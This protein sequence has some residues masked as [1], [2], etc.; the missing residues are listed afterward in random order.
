MPSSHPSPRDRRPLAALLLLALAVLAVPAIAANPPD[1]IDLTVARG[2]G[3]ADVTLTWSGGALPYRVYRSATAGV[4]TDLPSYLGEAAFSNVWV[5]TPPAGKVFFYRVVMCT[6]GG[7]CGSGLCA[8]GWCCD[9]A[10]DATCEA[11]NVAGSEGACTF[12]PVGEDPAN[13]CAGAEVCN[14]VG[15]CGSDPNGAPCTTD[16]EC[17]SGHCAD[18]VCCDS[19]CIGVCEA[20]GLAGSE[21]TCSLVP[22]GA[23]PDNECSAEPVTT[24]GRTGQCSGSGSCALHAGGTVCGAASCADGDTANPTDLCDGSG[25]CVATGPQEC[26]PYT[27]NGGNGL[28][29]TLCTACSDCTPGNACD[30]QSFTCV[31]QGTL[32][33]LPDPGFVDS[34]CDGIDGDVTGAVF[35]D[36]LGGNDGNLGTMNQPVRTLAAAILLASVAGKDV[37]ISRGTYAEPVILASG[38]SLYGAYDAALGWSRAP[39]NTVTISGSSTQV[40]GDSLSLPLELQFVNVVAANATGP[41]ASSYAL[42]LKSCTAQVTVTHSS[43]TAGAGSAGTAGVNGTAGAS[44]TAG[45]TGQSGCEDSSWPCDSCSQPSGGSGGTSA[46]GRTGGVGGRPGNGDG[47]GQTGGAGVGPTAGGLGGG[48]KANGAVGATGAAGAAGGDGSGGFE[49]G[50]ALATGYASAAGGGGAAGSDGNGGGGG[51]G[52]GGGNVDCDSYGSSGGGGGA[53]GCAGT[54]ALAGGGGGGS[55][56]V[57]LHVSTVSI[58]NS[59]LTSAAGGSGGAGG[60]GGNGG[61]GGNAGP[62]G[63]YGGS[64]EQDDGGNGGAGG[65]GGAGGRGGHGGGGGGGPTIAIECAGGS[66]AT[67]GSG[68]V[69]TPGAGGA[70]GASSGNPGSS[71]LAVAQHGC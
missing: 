13:E 11:C 70:G 52:G 12:I 53:G 40:R 7:D 50:A 5:D 21:G 60:L 69:L 9:S 44:G 49:F 36:A 19:A 54:G 42:L 10:C 71:G 6:T 43:L 33:D 27:C 48:S 4:I 18:S 45:G 32:P 58:S 3:A 24:C 20:C 22:A 56:A 30:L 14:G 8:D 34:N 23:D 2:P 66:T 41:G 46:C 51:G 67:L 28:C 62:G 47:S 15:S 61:N 29:R 64:G 55:F 59:T 1:G 17:L 65:A 16:G 35:V 57:Y 31:A 68:N 39:G 37:Y 26:A 63:P 25:T 38:V